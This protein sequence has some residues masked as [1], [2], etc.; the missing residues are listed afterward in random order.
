MNGSL[1]YEHLAVDQ[2]HALITIQEGP[3]PNIWKLGGPT[4]YLDT[5][6]KGNNL[7]LLVFERLRISCQ[8]S[9]LRGLTLHSHSETGWE[10]HKLKFCSSILHCLLSI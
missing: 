6:G 4:A 3:I 7:T 9:E 10:S 1:R 2:L 8:V 5:M